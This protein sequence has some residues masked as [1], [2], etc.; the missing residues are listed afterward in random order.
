MALGF[1]N[2]GGWNWPKNA[3]LGMAS[4]NL[5]NFCPDLRGGGRAWS[6]IVL[7]AVRRRTS[8]PTST[9]S[10]SF[11]NKP[12]YIKRKWSLEI[13]LIL[14]AAIGNWK[15]GPNVERVAPGS[16]LLRALW[17]LS[18]NVFSA[19]V[20]NQ[21]CRFCREREPLKQKS[22]IFSNFRNK[23]NAGKLLNYCDLNYIP[24]V[25]FM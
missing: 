22:Y 20:R 18:V 5:S 24:T 10:S 12:T 6:L 19:Q 23:T 15:F 14:L 7:R 21:I 2:S 4:H 17:L 13:V 25:S 11:G 9:K 3:G 8:D 1:E 16:T